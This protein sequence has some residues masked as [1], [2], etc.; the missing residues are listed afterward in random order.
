MLS[1][2]W[3]SAL[4]LG[5]ISAH[6]LQ[7]LCFPYFWKDFFF[8]LSLTRYGM[9]L[10]LFRLTSRVFTVLDRFI[11]Q[12]HRN[13]D[14]AFIIYEGSVH[15]YKDIEQ[16]SNRLANVFLQKL[17][18]T[19]GDCVALLMNNE[20]DFVCVWFGLAK[21]GCPVAFLNTNIKSRSLLHCITC[22]GAKAVIVG[23]GKYIL[24]HQYV[25]LVT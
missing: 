5:I 23:A 10:E 20:P 25:V 22:C 19:K 1:F 12:A 3:I 4:L 18:V 11:Q 21:V 17:N 13:P 8:L 7:K 9:K 14:K 6:V 2:A 16:R 24:L 15:T